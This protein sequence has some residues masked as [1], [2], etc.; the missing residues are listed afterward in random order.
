MG[1]PLITSNIP[2]CKE[3]VLEGQS[4][5]LCEPK[6]AESLYDTMSQFLKL[7]VQQREAMGLAGR[8]H[9]EKVFDKKHVVAQT[10]ASLQA[11]KSSAQ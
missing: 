7:T 2:G 1:R 10:I 8:R 6:N 3:A 11:E 9:M 4:G 5:M